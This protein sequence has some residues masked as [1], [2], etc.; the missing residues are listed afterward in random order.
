MSDKKVVVIGLDGVGYN[1]IKAWID[2]GE[3]PTLTRI[4]KEGCFGPL[5]S[6]IPP[7][8]IPAWASFSTGK[9]PGKLGIFYFV[10]NPLDPDSKVINLN[11]LP[12]RHLWEE[13]CNQ[14]KVCCIIN[15][16]LIYPP[17]KIRGTIICG[18]GVPPRKRDYVY[19]STLIRDLDHIDYKVDIEEYGLLP[20]SRLTTLRKKVIY[21]EL[22][23][24]AKAR[25]KALK[26]TAKKRKHDFFFILFKE[27]DIL[28]HLF[29]DDKEKMLEYFKL[30]DGYIEEIVSFFGQDTNY[31]IMSD[32][33]FHPAPHREFYINSW[34]KNK[35][36]VD[37][38]VPLLARLFRKE[39]WYKLAKMMGEHR[40]FSILS[41]KILK[42]TSAFLKEWPI[43]GT[44]WGIY[45]DKNFGRYEE[46]RERL[47]QELRSLNEGGRKVF[48]MVSKRE[49]IYS[50]KE[51]EKA[52]DI[53]W[54]P[55]PEYR[56][57]PFVLS[58]KNFGSRITYL[59]GEHSSDL[60]GILIAYGPD[61]KNNYLI[62]EAEIIDLAPTILHLM[63]CRIP[64]DMDG[65]VLKEILKSPLATKPE[66]RYDKEILSKEKIKRKL[67]TL[68]Y[69][70]RKG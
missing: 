55:S 18:F 10:E 20:D 63:G 37:F 24:I 67:R 6:T 64:N 28:Q 59:A 54:V 21:Q 2:G 27:T 60:Y 39:L 43:K 19:P 35:K 62:K 58:K 25:V 70:L 66:I 44:Y 12:H 16:P 65:R 51:V 52:P 4:A 68:K 41:K 48:L 22:I 46:V 14:G 56:V 11:E 50:G 5:K 36:Y 53:I 8:T 38:N 17:K 31:I 1:L 15:F 33:G 26:I 9:N 40:P 57:N 23:K 42:K 34:L 49:D 3:L 30:I 47:I 29:F 13:L 69:Q 45:I 7:T 61:F 32:H